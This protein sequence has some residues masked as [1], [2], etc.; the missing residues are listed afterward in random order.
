MKHLDEYTSVSAILENL[1]RRENETI[2]LYERVDRETGDTA[3]TSLLQF[4]IHEKQHHRELLEN[5]L[6]EM[7]E[8][9]ELDEAVI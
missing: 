7:N 8:H 2:A 9:F 1:I 5:E 4:L 3:V 6:K